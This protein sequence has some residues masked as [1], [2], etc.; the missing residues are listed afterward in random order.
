VSE[1]LK[2]FKYELSF[3]KLLVTPSCEIDHMCDLTWKLLCHAQASPQLTR[4]I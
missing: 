4:T 2:D 3:D 1:T